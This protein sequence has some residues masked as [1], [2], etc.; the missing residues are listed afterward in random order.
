MRCRTSPKSTMCALRVSWTT[1]K[2]PPRLLTSRGGFN[3]EVVR[4]IIRTTS[5]TTL[6][7]GFFL[8]PLGLLLIPYYSLQSG[9]QARE[10]LD[11]KKNTLCVQLA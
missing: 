1:D 8:S 10:I 7:T 6:P 2:N 9:L 4:M 11:L 5:L 3:Q